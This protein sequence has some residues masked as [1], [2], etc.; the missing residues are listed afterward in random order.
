MVTIPFAFQ[1]AKY[2]S[3]KSGDT[4]ESRL[5]KKGV[6]MVLRVVPVEGKDLQA[7]LDEL[8][9]L[10]E[11]ITEKDNLLKATQKQLARLHQEA[12]QVADDIAE[13]IKIEKEVNARLTVLKAEENLALLQGRKADHSDS[14]GR[15]AIDAN[16]QA[17][18]SS[19]RE[20]KKQQGSFANVF[21]LPMLEDARTRAKESFLERTAQK[22]KLQQAIREEEA[23]RDKLASELQALQARYELFQANPMVSRFS[24][25]PYKLTEKL[26]NDVEM[27][28]SVLK[29]L[30]PAG[31]SER[32]RLVLAQ[33]PS[34]L[35]QIYQRAPGVGTL[36]EQ[37]KQ[38]RQ[39]YY[40]CCGLLYDVYD[41]VDH[42]NFRDRLKSLVES[43]GVSKADARNA[44][45]KNKLAFQTAAEFGLEQHERD[46]YANAKSQLT[47]WLAQAEEGS[48]KRRA[49]ALVEA[50]GNGENDRKFDRPFYTQFLKTTLEAAKAPDNREKRNQY[51]NTLQE[52]P[53]G[54]PSTKR[55]I[56]GC[57]LVLL[58]VFVFAASAVVKCLSLGVASP[59]T[60]AGMIGGGLLVASG[61]GLFA[62]GCGRGN[63]KKGLALQESLEKNAKKMKLS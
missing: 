8:D 37:T 6:V 40:E 33:L 32:L 58:G 21:V 41:S 12:T 34:L 49:T 54:K 39:A 44:Y 57:G 46:E 20:A 4:L 47:N 63:Y 29:Q 19:L 13:A 2:A 43:T 3:W 25:E 10:P 7:W 17:Q 22:E 18:E 42:A 51:R 23:S 30:F 27:Q 35:R 5:N 15:G 1:D 60:L 48:L 59:I 53:D 26:I 61:I 16:I 28:I 38:Y 56:L 55:K 24:K 52:I 9:G 62:S 31:Q 36:A 45:E 11:K 50:I 14:A